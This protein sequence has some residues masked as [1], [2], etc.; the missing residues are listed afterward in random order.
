MALNT[1]GYKE[2]QEENIKKTFFRGLEPVIT[3]PVRVSNCDQYL[4]RINGQTFVNVVVTAKRP[5]VAQ[6][7]AE[8]SIK[9]LIM[10]LAKKQVVKIHCSAS[11]KQN[12]IYFF[13]Y[14][15]DEIVIKNTTPVL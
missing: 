2:K 8:K 11:D 9:G 12:D 15:L 7:M 4:A 14:N 1:V 3:G 10:D 13:K 6:M 5:D